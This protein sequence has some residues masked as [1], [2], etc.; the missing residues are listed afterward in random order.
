MNLILR[1]PRLEDKEKYLLYLDEW[2]DKDKIIP[3]SSRLL[4]RTYETFV[5]ELIPRE[6]GLINP[7]K[8]VPEI[9]HILVDEEGNIYGALSFRLKLNEHLLAFDGHIGY[10]IAPSKRGQGYGKLILK[11]A[12]DCAR[13]KG[14]KKVLL[15]CNEENKRSERV[16]LSQGGILENKVYK[17]DGYI[18]RYW[19]NL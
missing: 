10:G 4:G 9:I 14:F 5:E 6:K 15:T 3:Y 16:I 17:T 8:L 11:L 12:L 1:Y 18:M 2:E 13:S 7:D 19:I